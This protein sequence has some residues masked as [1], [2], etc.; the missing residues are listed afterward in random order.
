M[1]RL[2]LA[3]EPGFQF[4]VENLVT[5]A[6]WEDKNWS[7]VLCLV[8]AIVSRNINVLISIPVGLLGAVVI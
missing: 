2:C 7:L 6:L 1:Q 3:L 4:I 5:L 8:R